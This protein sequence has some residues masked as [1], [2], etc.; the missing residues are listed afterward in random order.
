MDGYEVLKRLRADPATA[1][2][3][4]VALSANAKPDDLA[5]GHAAG[6]DD[7]LTKPLDVARLLALLDALPRPQA[8]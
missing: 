1:G 7:Y 6:F 2:L 5:R 8:R 3:Q 4:V